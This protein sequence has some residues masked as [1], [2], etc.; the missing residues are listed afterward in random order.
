VIKH[1]TVILEVWVQFL[2]VLLS[3]CVIGSSWLAFV[4]PCFVHQMEIV[5]LANFLPSS[6]V[7]SD[8]FK[9]FRVHS[10]CIKHGMLFLFYE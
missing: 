1:W 3:P 10:F 8:R 4:S 2:A 6:I 7:G 9:M 5:D